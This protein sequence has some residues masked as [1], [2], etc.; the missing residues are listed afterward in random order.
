MG[1]H[2]EQQDKMRMSVGNQIFHRLCID[3]LWKFSGRSKRP[4]RRNNLHLSWSYFSD[5]LKFGQAG[6]PTWYLQTMC[7]YF[8]YPLSLRVIS[9]R[10]LSSKAGGRIG[11]LSE[12]KHTLFGE[13]RSAVHSQSNSA[14]CNSVGSCQG[15]CFFRHGVINRQR[16][17]LKKINYTWLHL[18][19]M[20]LRAGRGTEAEKNPCNLRGSIKGAICDIKLIKLQQKLILMGAKLVTSWQQR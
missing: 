6:P 17:N 8:C 16:Q 13:P 9:G 15:Q 2:K 1:C 5:V 12:M 11:F 19:Y 3:C 14:S 4:A 18:T 20:T 7:C 10:F